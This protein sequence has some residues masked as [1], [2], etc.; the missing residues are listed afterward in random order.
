MAALSAQRELDQ[1]P[2]VQ[3]QPTSH[4]RA[5]W[6]GLWVGR[7]RVS[8][9]SAAPRVEPLSL[10]V[11]HP[12]QDHAAGNRWCCTE[13]SG[14]MGNKE[15]T[16]DFVGRYQFNYLKILVVQSKSENGSSHCSEG[17]KRK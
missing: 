10:L 17:R 7:L 3:I 1:W 12:F 14:E 9:G 15:P 8:S 11:Y 16:S 13:A 2:K 6:K 5:E 4:L